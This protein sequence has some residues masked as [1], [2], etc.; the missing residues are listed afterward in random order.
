MNGPK[1]LRHI[2]LTQSGV[3]TVDLPF[4][5]TFTLYFFS[6]QSRDVQSADVDAV[7]WET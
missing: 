7:G 2:A 5:T 6:S 4:W 1:K 3:D